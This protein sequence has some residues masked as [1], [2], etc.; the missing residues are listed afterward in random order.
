M[1][2]RA[3][4]PRHRLGTRRGP[5]S[6]AT[7]P[8]PARPAP[9]PGRRGCAV[10][11]GRRCPGRRCRIDRFFLATRHSPLE[12]LGTDPRRLR[13][14]WPRAAN[15]SCRST[16]I[17]PRLKSTNGSSRRSASSASRI[18]QSR[19]SFRSRSAGSVSPVC[20]TVTSVH[21]TGTFTRRNTGKICSCTAYVQ[22]TSSRTEFPISFETP[23]QSPPVYG[24]C[25]CND[26][27]GSPSP[28]D[29]RETSFSGSFPELT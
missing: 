15:Q 13:W 12:S 2:P 22:R 5:S 28:D 25:F 18:L 21:R 6:G 19:R 20:R 7:G 10:S 14:R 29:P 24:W 11:G 3:T 16:A 26:L 9:R 1:F 17:A 8:R 23:R 4:W 27:P